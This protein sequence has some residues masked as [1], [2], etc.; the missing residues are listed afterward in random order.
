[1]HLGHDVDFAVGVDSFGEFYA[2]H[3][4]CH[5][6]LGIDVHG[7]CGQRE[8]VHAVA[9]FEGFEVAVAQRDAEHVGY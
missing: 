8:E 4:G 1:M 6:G 5:I 7:E 2:G 3:V 9:F